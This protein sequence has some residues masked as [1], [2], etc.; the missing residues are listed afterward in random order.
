MLRLANLFC[1]FRGKYE[2]TH[3]P[4]YPQQEKL[5]Q[6]L[7]WSETKNHQNPLD[8]VRSRD[9]RP[10]GN[11]IASAFFSAL[12]SEVAVTAKEPKVVEGLG[13]DDFLGF[14]FGGNFF[15]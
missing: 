3:S 11:W 7:G 14:L 8:L 12:L 9:L 5:L 1:F 13:S 10:E 15:V 4:L 6:K 2:K